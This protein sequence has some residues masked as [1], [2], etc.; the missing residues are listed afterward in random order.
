MW[1]E[2]L[3]ASSTTGLPLVGFRTLLGEM[4]FSTVAQQV[5]TLYGEG[6][7][8]D[9]LSLIADAR[10]ALPEQDS[11]LTFWEACLRSISGNPKQAVDVLSEGT[12]RGLWWPEGMLADSDLDAARRTEAWREIV[13]ACRDREA[14]RLAARPAVRIREGS[15]AGTVIAL[16]GARDDPPAF[17]DQWEAAVP[18]GWTVVTPVGDV[19]VPEGGWSWAHDQASRTNAVVRQTENVS[20]DAPLILAGFSAGATLALELAASELQPAGLILFAPFIADSD[21]FK[22]TIEKLTVPAVWGYGTDDRAADVYRRLERPMDETV[23]FEGV[24]H[25]LPSSLSVVF[26][27]ASDLVDAR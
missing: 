15:G 8:S 9:A 23:V 19:A 16:H 18:Q 22:A 7:Y 4:E 21:Q 2:T 6:R 10:Q 26:R 13:S 5:H 1:A 3:V 11:R 24:G 17:A 14:E 27:A 20:I 12:T 25:S